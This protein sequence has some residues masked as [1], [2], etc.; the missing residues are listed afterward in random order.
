MLA[1]VITC[2]TTALRR[3]GQWPDRRGPSASASGLR[4]SVGER[5]QSQ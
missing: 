2:G 1:L 5:T 4:A 3:A